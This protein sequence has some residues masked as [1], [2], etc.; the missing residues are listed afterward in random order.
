MGYDTDLL[1]ETTLKCGC[2]ESKY[3]VSHDFFGGSR[4]FTETIK[5]FKHKTNYA[6]INE[7]DESSDD[8]EED[9]SS[10]VEETIIKDQEK[11]H[12]IV[13]PSYKVFLHVPFEYKTDAK[14]L[15]SHF[16]FDKKKWYI[17]SGSKHHAT[18]VKIFNSN[19][20]TTSYYGTKMKL[21]ILEQLTEYK[22]ECKEEITQMYEDIKEHKESYE[23]HLEQKNRTFNCECGGKYKS[24]T[25]SSHYNTKKH[26]HYIDC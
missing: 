20:F 15:D 8:E 24:T 12:P 16:D 25:K 21:S 26:Q 2:I 6:F 22:E 7:E 10:L 11:I 13:I 1:K 17:Y 3:K 5:C 18:L 9:E 14:E 23:R 4:L 19:N